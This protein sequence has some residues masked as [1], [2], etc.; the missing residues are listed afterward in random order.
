MLTSSQYSFLQKELFRIKI[1]KTILKRCS[2]FFSKILGCRDPR[3][4]HEYLDSRWIAKRWHGEES[5]KHIEARDRRYSCLTFCLEMKAGLISA[6]GVT[7]LTR[8]ITFREDTR[9]AS[10]LW[11]KSDRTFVTWRH[12]RLKGFNLR[13]TYARLLPL[14]STSMSLKKCHLQGI[15]RRFFSQ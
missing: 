6:I 10:L 7:K 4:K 3:Y 5:D 2:I 1:E 9:A 15:P 14:R 11:K 13:V 12:F 8:Q